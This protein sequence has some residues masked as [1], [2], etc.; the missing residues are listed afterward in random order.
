MKR[1]FPAPVLSAAI[2][3]LWLL[4]NRTVDATQLLLGFIVAVA[5]PV[6]SAPLR[7]TPVRIRRPGT[8]LRLVLAVMRDVVVSNAQVA[9]LI[10]TRRKAGPRSA[11]VA[12]PLEMRDPNGLAALAL[13]TTVVPGTVWSE[14]SLEGDMLLLHVFDVEDTAAFIAHY[15]D[16]YERPLREI[17]E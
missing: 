15:K 3:V 5:A 12:I 16:R 1:L 4:L 11:F 6:L 2:F 9:W 8:L 13:I 14:F 17:F 10:L 7:P